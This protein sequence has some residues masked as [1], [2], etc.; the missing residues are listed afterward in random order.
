MSIQPSLKEY[1]GFHRYINVTFMFIKVQ[2]ISREFANVM[3]KRNWCI[4]Y[5][6]SR[7]L[8][9]PSSARHFSQPFIQQVIDIIDPYLIQTIILRI[10]H[11]YGDCQSFLSFPAL[12]QQFLPNHD[13]SLQLCAYTEQEQSKKARMLVKGRNTQ[14]QLNKIRPSTASVSHRGEHRP[15]TNCHHPSTSLHMA[16]Y[17]TLQLVL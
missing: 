8:R 10:Y 4:P 9:A 6:I 7:K 1:L 12:L 5:L 16:V 11:S 14:R 13:N 17:V 2:N 15:V 3:V